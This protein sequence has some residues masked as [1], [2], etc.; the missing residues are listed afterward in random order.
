[1]FV[2]GRELHFQPKPVNGDDYY[3]VVFVIDANNQTIKANAINPKFSRCLSIARDVSVEVV[4]FNSSTGNTVKR[5]ATKSRRRNSPEDV[6]NYVYTKPNLTPEQ[7]LQLAQSYLQQITE[8]EIVFRSDLFLDV[9]LD[10]VYPIKVSGTST[11]L[12]QIYFISKIE[13][14]LEFTGDCSMNVEAKN[15]STESEVSI[16]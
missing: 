11:K 6:Q 4:S 13:R 16:V 8:H 15:H 7:A 5:K 1:L 10:I 2:R 9:T 3:G 14:Y 12:D